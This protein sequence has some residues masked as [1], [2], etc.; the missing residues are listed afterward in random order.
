METSTLVGLSVFSCTLF[1]IIGPTRFL[2]AMKIVYLLIKLFVFSTYT[3][4]K[5][6]TKSVFKPSTRVVLLA[7]VSTPEEREMDLKR[8]KMRRPQTPQLI[9]KNQDGF[10]PVTRGS[11]VYTRGVLQPVVVVDNMGF[12][13]NQ[14]P[15]S[16]TGAS[17]D[18]DDTTNNNVIPPPKDGTS[19]RESA[20]LLPTPESAAL[21]PTPESAAL[22]PTRIDNDD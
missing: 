7:R 8:P 14:P 16:T 17:R 20:A 19:V 18:D 22:L 11:S 4:L 6:Y 13:T 1:Y 21:L 9:D 2:L 3:T 10:F 12:A 5:K 15:Q